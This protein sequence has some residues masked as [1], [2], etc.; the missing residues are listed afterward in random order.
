MRESVRKYEKENLTERVFGRQYEYECSMS[1]NVSTGMSDCK[2][3]LIVKPKKRVIMTTSVSI[4]LIASLTLNTSTCM[5]INVCT[6][7]LRS[8]NE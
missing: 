1:R 6:S 4:S 2:Y 7:L 3:E 5:N 8:L